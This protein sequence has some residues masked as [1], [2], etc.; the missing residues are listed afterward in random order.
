MLAGVFIVVGIYLIIILVRVNSVLRRID[1]IISY[2]DRIGA[3]IQSFE[4]IP[5]ALVVIIQQLA[6]VVLG[7]VKARKKRA[8]SESED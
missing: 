6:G 4:A 1:T 7:K 5:A 2:T 3:L 8:S